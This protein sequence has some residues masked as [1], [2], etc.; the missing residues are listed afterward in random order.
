MDPV[1]RDAVHPRL[2][3]DEGLEG[4]H[5]APSHRG[6]QPAPLDDAGDVPETALRLPRRGQ[7]HIDLGPGETGSV[8]A[9]RGQRVSRDAQLPELRP[10]VSRFDPQIDEGAEEHVA[11]D[12]G[13]T[14]EVQPAHHPAP[15]R[16]GSTSAAGPRIT[17]SAT[18][19]NGVSSMLISTR[20]APFC[21]A[22]SGKAA[23][24]YTSA[25]V[26]MERKTS[27]RRAAS[28]ASR[29]ASS[30]SAS[31][32]QTTSGRSSAPHP[33]RGG[34]SGRGT[35]RSSREVPSFMQ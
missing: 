29:I 30:G 2:G 23:A 35:R 32:N 22:T 34:I 15:R 11:A 6:G 9:R 26:P 1:L 21:L 24:G 19:D 17:S 10:Q 28:V 25:E 33:Q 7:F 8:D 3:L 4:V 18:G 16:S 13:E 27:E 20:Y 14:V 5:G 31:P 12:P